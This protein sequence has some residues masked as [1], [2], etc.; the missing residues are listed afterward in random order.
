MD[1]LMISEIQSKLF[2]HAAH[3]DCLAFGMCNKYD[4]EK[5]NSFSGF[6]GD[7]QLKFFDFSIHMC[8]V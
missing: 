2:K 8:T 3:A 7:N 5:K 6:F 4:D 1:Q